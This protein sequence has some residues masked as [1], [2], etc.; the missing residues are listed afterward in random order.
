MAGGIDQT[1][2]KALELKAAVLQSKATQVL[3]ILS[4]VNI[5]EPKLQIN[6]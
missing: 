6:T 2:L 4:D 1:K 3:T 5:M